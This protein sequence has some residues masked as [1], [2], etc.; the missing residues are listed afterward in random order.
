MTDE[1]YQATANL[2]PE[3]NHHPQ[4]GFLDKVLKSTRFST[5]QKSIGNRS[6]LVIETALFD[7]TGKVALL[8]GSSKGM[9]QHG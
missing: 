5:M 6:N 1:Q 8:T 4:K 7:L 9:G 3:I 2:S